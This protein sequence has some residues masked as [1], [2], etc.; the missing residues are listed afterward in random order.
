MNNLNEGIDIDRN[1][2]TVAFNDTHEYNVD[3]SLEHNPSFRTDIIN[4]V[5]IWSIFQR[6]RSLSGDGNPLIYAYKNEKGWKFKSNKDKLFLE[7]R[8]Q[9]LVDKFI[10]THPG[11]I[12][13]VMPSTNSL[14]DYIASIL[15]KRASNYVFIRDIMTKITV[16]EAEEMILDDPYSKFNQTFRG[17]KKREAIHKLLRYFENMNNKK[18]GV[19]VRHM[20]LDDDIRNSIDK[21]FKFSN[22]IFAEYSNLIN[23]NNVLVLD[24]TISRGQSAKEVCDMLKISYKPKSIAVLTLMSKLK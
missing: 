4:G 3:T 14:N 6:K 17:N 1:L 13:I 21:T 10:L 2:K 5:E 24:D 12:V 8:I 16:G 22:S 15:S 7:Y 23:F 19:F 11:E 9:E 20:I 18:R